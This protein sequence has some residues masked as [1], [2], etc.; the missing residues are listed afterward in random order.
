MTNS[1]EWKSFSELRLCLNSKINGQELTIVK[2]TGRYDI[3]IRNNG[4]MT[5]FDHTGAE[6]MTNDDFIAN[7]GQLRVIKSDVYNLKE[8]C[9]EQ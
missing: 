8:G 4:V 9:K 2:K 5:V 1:L 7:D 6:S 3:Q